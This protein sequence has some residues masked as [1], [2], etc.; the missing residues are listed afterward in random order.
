[1]QVLTAHLCDN[2]REFVL[3]DNLAVIKDYSERVAEGETVPSGEC[4]E[5]GCLCHE[6]EIKLRPRFKVKESDEFNSF[7]VFGETREVQGLDGLYD[8]AINESLNLVRELAKVGYPTLPANPKPAEQV[9]A[10][11]D[12]ALVFTDLIN[13]ARSIPGAIET[14]ES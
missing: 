11:A 8:T 4:P 7:H 5:C 1:M 10:M 12:F 2:C 9:K 13:K 3:E 14:K 6:V